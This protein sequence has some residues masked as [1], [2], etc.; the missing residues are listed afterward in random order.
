MGSGMSQRN[1]AKR[2]ISALQ[3]QGKSLQKVRIKRG[4]IVFIAHHS[5]IPAKD[6]V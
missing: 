4:K 6:E 2:F 3:R 1:A 5:A